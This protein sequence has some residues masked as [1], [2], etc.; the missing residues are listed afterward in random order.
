[1]AKGIELGV[2]VDGRPFKEGI[3]SGV[4]APLDDATETLKTVG[5]D[6]SLE[7]LEDDLKGAQRA[8]RELADETKKTG[9]EITQK[10][11]KAFREMKEAAKSGYDD[12]GEAAKEFKQEATQNM[13]ELASSFKGDMS[14]IGDAVQG[15]LGG[16][17]GSIAGPAGIALGGLGVIAGVAFSNITERAERM[18][19]DVSTQ[20]QR[21][22]EN[23]GGALDE[24]EKR[25][26][27]AEQLDTNWELIQKVAEKTG[28]EADRVA[29]SLALGGDKAT[30]IEEKLK[31]IA[32][33]QFGGERTDTWNLSLRFGELA[34]ASELAGQKYEVMLDYERRVSTQQGERLQSLV[35]KV[36]A[37][38]E[39]QTLEVDVDTAAIDREL[40]KRRTVTVDFVD[41][42]G[43]RIW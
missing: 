18:T 24:L 32:G 2:G 5:Q 11:R 16:L 21:M 36:N 41:R 27:V 13:S 29:E 25:K 31:S 7:Q 1:M 30:A 40:A 28:L 3:E 15:T 22:V 4:I 37:L 6:K 35:D 20:F 43:K 38:P 26:L 23:G 10:S 33:G 12:S 34:A 42:T 17:A 9:Q 39:K 19:E 14:S 8:S